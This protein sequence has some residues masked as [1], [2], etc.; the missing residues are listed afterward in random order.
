MLKEHDKTF[1]GI[2][3]AVDLGV[4]TASFAVGAAVCQ[5]L[6]AVE[7]LPGCQDGVARTHFP[8]PPSTR[9]SSLPALAVGPRLPGGE[10]PIQYIGLRGHGQFCGTTPSATLCGSC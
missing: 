6:K 10:G 3:R 2:A 8:R 9:F 1:V 7:P 4:I 5:R